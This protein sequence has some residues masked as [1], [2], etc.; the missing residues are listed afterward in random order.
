M[1]CNDRDVRHQR[2]LIQRLRS[3]D[4]SAGWPCHD[5]LEIELLGAGLIERRP[6]PRGGEHIGLTTAG[7][8][9]LG[10]ALSSNRGA[11]SAHEALVERVALDLARA[12]RLVW[13]ELNL[14]ARIGATWKS[15]RPDV[16]S[17]R[18]TTRATGTRPVI[19]E[20]KV[21]RADLLSDLQQ[22]DKRAAYRALSAEFF[23][24]MPRGL[25]QLHEIPDDSGVL[26]A[27]AHTTGPCLK[28]GRASPRRLLQPE[29]SVWMALARRGADPVDAEP[30]QLRLG[31]A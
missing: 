1:P 16:Y 2:A 30:A 21:H 18:N 3:Y 28:L 17:I 14:R 23:Y 29:L 13:R 10:A 27:D 24:V 4:R 8:D 25:A 9:A 15:C 12:G 7:I 20:I 6:Q 31:P 22:A 11:K 5:T 26:W 19:H